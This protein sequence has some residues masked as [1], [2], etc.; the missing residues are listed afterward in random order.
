MAPTSE[1]HEAPVDIVAAVSDPT[2]T[3]ANYE[4]EPDN[5]AAFFRAWVNRLRGGEIGVLPVVAGLILLVAIFQ[6]EN[7]TFLTAGNLTNLIGQGAQYMLLGM[8][9]VFVLLLGEID[10]SIGFLMGIGAAITCILA[11]TPY[12]EPWWVACLAGIGGTTAIGTIQGLLVT[13]LGLPSFVVTLAGQLGFSGL[14]I[15]LINSSNGSGVITV[16]NNVI[17]DIVNG[18]M[19]PV[20]GWIVMVAVVV[21]FGGFMIFRDQRRRK[22]G[23]HAQPLGVTLLKIVVMAAAGIGVVVIG[24]SNRGLAGTAGLRGVP[25]VTLLVL[26]VLGVYEFTLGR[27]RFGRYF[28]AIGGNAEAARRAGVNLRF[29]RTSAFAL[30]G[31]TSGIAGIVLASRLGSISTDLDGGTEVLYAVAAAVIGGTS[32]FGGRGKMLH[33][34]LGGI[35]IATIYNGLGLLGLSAQATYIVAALVLLVAVTVDAVARRNSTKR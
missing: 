11:T 26:A 21:F 10:L 33:A 34:L 9:E 14:L 17:N 19:S 24:N 27:T 31:L 32:L 30:S 20:A 4:V 16:T 23:L 25:W 18:N 15:I 1:T 28:Y 3:A 7:S 8:A 35:V 6:A 13:L 22:H 2:A 29:I 5:L 12:N